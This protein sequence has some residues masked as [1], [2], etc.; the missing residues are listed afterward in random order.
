[1]P[2]IYHPKGSMCTVCVNNKL[3]CGKALD[4]KF[5]PVMSQYGVAGDDSVYKIVKCAMFNESKA[6]SLTKTHRK[7][8]Q[9]KDY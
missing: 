6:E 7:L 4:F 8:V 5:M 9:F 1:M 2:N 3:D